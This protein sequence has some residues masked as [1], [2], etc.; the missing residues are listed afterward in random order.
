MRDSTPCT[1]LTCLAQSLTPATNNSPPIST[2]PITP[3]P[4]PTASASPRINPQ[5]CRLRV[6]TPCLVRARSERR[7]GDYPRCLPALSIHAAYPR[8]LSALPIRAAYP[9]CLSTLP[10]HAAYPRCLPAM[11]IHA[12]YSRCLSALPIHAAYP[13]CLSTLPIHAAYPHCLS[14]LPIGAA[15]VRRARNRSD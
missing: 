3:V 4:P 2:A 13:R 15:A 11:P 6:R 14:P 5:L 10:I 12:A 1:R 7:P 9:R 8:C